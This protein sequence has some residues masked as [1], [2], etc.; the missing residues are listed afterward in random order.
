M[1]IITNLEQL[2]KPSQGLTQVATVAATLRHEL[3]IRPDACGLAA[4]Q[5]G[6]PA[7]I[8][9][10]RFRNAS[11]LR[12]PVVVMIEPRIS[13]MDDEVIESVEGCLSLPDKL[14][15]VKRHIA[16]TVKFVDGVTGIPWTKHLAGIDAITVQHE[17]DHLNGIL[18]CDKGEELP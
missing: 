2:R 10:V 9:A 15:K 6:R 5:I 14:Y 13:R 8:I 11:G 17:I 16:L 1:D 4:V 12:N 3:M 18:I 7:R